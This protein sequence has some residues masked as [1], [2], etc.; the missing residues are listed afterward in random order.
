M[1]KID[2]HRRKWLALGSAAMGIALLPGQAFASLSTSRPRILVV[3]NMHTGETLK[4]EFFDGKGYNKDELVRLNHLFRDYR[5]NKIKPID[6]RLFDQLYRLQGLLGTNKPV[7]LVSG[8]R[9][10]IP[11]MSCVSAAAVWPSTAITPK[12]RRWTSIS[13]ASN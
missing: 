8:Y 5:A 3:N 7:Q 11:T 13:K 2:H 12:A 10:W 6:P 9:S 1:D 4:A